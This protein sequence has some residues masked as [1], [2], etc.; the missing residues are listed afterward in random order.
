MTTAENMF[1]RLHFAKYSML[2]AKLCYVIFDIEDFQAT[3]EQHIS[4]VVFKDSL[5]VHR[6]IIEWLG[7]EG[8]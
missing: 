6:I 2:V 3:D 7:L 8:T 5:H 4:S 1:N